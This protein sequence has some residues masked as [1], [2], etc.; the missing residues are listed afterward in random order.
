[1]TYALYY[2]VAAPEGQLE[3]CPRYREDKDALMY[4]IVATNHATGSAIQAELTKGGLVKV[5]VPNSLANSGFSL[6]N[7]NSSTTGLLSSFSSW[8]PTFDGRTM[9][10]VVAPGGSI[11]SAFPA[12]LG[13]WSVLDG[14]SMST[15]YLAG[16]AA[17]VKQYNRQ[18][19]AAQIQAKL[20]STARPINYNNRKGNGFYAGET[21]D[22][23]ASVLHQG[24]GLVDAWAAA[25]TKTLLNVLSLNFNDTAHRPAHLSFEISNT[26]DEELI[27]NMS[28]I[29]A[30]SGFFMNTT[31]GAKYNLSC[32]EG[33]P[34]FALLKFEPQTVRIGPEKTASVAVSVAAE[35][36]LEGGPSFFGGYVAL[37][38]STPKA[39]TES[40]RLP[41]TGIKGNLATLPMVDRDH[42]YGG[43]MNLVSGNSERIEPQRVFKC[44][45][46]SKAYTPCYFVPD[47]LV[48]SIN[49]W[50]VTQTR[51]MT[52]DLVNKATGAVVLP[53]FF[54]TNSSRP[55]TNDN[56]Y[57]WN[58][59]DVNNTFVPPGAHVWRITTQRLNADSRTARDWDVWE[60]T[61]WT[62]IYTANSSGLPSQKREASQPPLAMGRSDGGKSIILY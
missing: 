57:Y 62:L 36:E 32:N 4:G 14:T 15:P 51:N 59:T 23:F 58:A 45:Y 52:V 48:P 42:T 6:S 38:V 19:T 43:A 49:I 56:P 20:T 29:G 26:G 30:A 2:N 28:H 37:N 33:I 24:G 61:P 53:G 46:D 7:P 54:E 39:Y 18:L 8:G 22:F 5:A 35:P 16:V 50:L 55:W 27:Y 40:L 12:R 41:Y 34:S 31:A 17:L 11:L 10:S 21:Q 9:P 1:M 3:V 13:S 60:S 44:S 25:H 47:G